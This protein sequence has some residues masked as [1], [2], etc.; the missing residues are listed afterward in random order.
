MGFFWLFIFSAPDLRWCWNEN[1]PRKLLFMCTIHKN[2]RMSNNFL[3]EIIKEEKRTCFSGFSIF[4]TLRDQ[5]DK[6][7]FPFIGKF[8]SSIKVETPHLSWAKKSLK[9][10]L[11]SQKP[12]HFRKHSIFVNIIQSIDMRPCTSWV[13]D[14]QPATVYICFIIVR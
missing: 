5:K 7:S 9:I 8:V 3:L 10:Y 11:F 14:L 2:M 12:L 4:E 13:S 6:F 1:A